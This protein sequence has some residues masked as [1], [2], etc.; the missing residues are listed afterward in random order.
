M[1]ENAFSVTDTLQAVTDRDTPLHTV[2]SVTNRDRD[3]VRQILRRLKAK[4]VIRPY[5]NKEGWY[6]RVDDRAEEIDFLNASTDAFNI[7]WPFQIE[8]YVKTHPKNIIIVAGSPNAGK[9]AFL[10]NTVAMN[11]QRQKVNWF[12]SEMGPIELKERLSKFDTPLA[13][14]KK[15]K[16]LERSSNFADVIRP[17]EINIIDFLEMTTEFYQVAGYIKDIFDKLTTGIAII[18]IQK[19]PGVALGLGGA[20]SLEKARLYLTMDAGKLKIEKG[21]N[22]ADP[23]KNPNGLEIKFKLAQGCH[24][25]SDGTWQREARP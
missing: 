13:D 9:T 11:M 25:I 7:S 15:V 1:T 20:R 16:W 22:W 3:N 17:D 10:L 8:H 18:A 2:T 14:F 6:I 24:F 4:G 19:N 12:S 23:T 5:G 21:K